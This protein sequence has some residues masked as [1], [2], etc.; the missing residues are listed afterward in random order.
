MLLCLHLFKRVCLEA[1]IF[2]GGDGGGHHAYRK[3]HEEHLAIKPL[4]IIII[5]FVVVGPN[6]QLS[7]GPHVTDRRTDT[8]MLFLTGV[9]FLPSKR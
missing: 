3:V 6:P 9:L 7:F 2:E 4:P 5:H 1:F 8:L